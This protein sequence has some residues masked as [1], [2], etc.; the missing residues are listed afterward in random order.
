[1]GMCVCVVEG[2]CVRSIL[3][4][5]KVG[6]GGTGSGLESNYTVALNASLRDRIKAI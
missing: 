5:T 6:C 1:M 2:I 3:S 4:T